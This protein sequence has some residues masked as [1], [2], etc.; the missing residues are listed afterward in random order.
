M[1][2][3]DHSLSIASYEGVRV[4]I[5]YDGT[6]ADVLAQCEEI[7]DQRR[8]EDADIEINPADVSQVE[9][10]VPIEV[11]ISAPCEP[12]MIIPPWFFA[13]RTLSASCTMVKE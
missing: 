4:G 6:N 7:L 11:T 12:N 3:L 9:R 10:G 13:G 2:F 1:I 8:V 5:N